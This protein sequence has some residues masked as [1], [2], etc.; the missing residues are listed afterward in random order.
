MLQPLG[1]GPRGTLSH[2]T[3]G[4]AGLM[5][6]GV[7]LGVGVGVEDGAGT[8]GAGALLGG[9]CGGVLVQADSATATA[10]RT[11]AGTTA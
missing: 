2:R 3:A 11:T 10:V 7:G 9:G 8:D 6:L 1:S 5:A 4:I